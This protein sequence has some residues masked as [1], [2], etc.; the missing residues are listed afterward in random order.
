MTNRIEIIKRV[1]N[2]PMRIEV[3]REVSRDAQPE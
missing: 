2:V 1:M 3:Q